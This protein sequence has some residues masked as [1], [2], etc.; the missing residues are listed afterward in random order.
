MKSSWGNVS[1]HE[2]E[3]G[4]GVD[5]VNSGSHHLVFNFCSPSSPSPQERQAEY[6]RDYKAT[7]FSSVIIKWHS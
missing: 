1:S 4:A 6:N 5:N 7:P 2:P 3:A